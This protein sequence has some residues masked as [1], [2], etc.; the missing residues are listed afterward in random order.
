MVSLS[1]IYIAWMQ[2]DSTIIFWNPNFI[3]Y[4]IPN[5]IAQSSVAR[6]EIFEDCLLAMT[7]NTSPKW[8]WMTH[9]KPTWPVHLQITTSIFILKFPSDETTKQLMEQGSQEVCMHIYFKFSKCW[10][11]LTTNGMGTIGGLVVNIDWKSSL[12]CTIH[13]ITC[14]SVYLCWLNT[15]SYLAFQI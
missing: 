14:A 13:S 10:N 8:F 4:L 1:T 6:G 5:E 2:S 9:L 3:L 15:L 7:P 11:H 12:T